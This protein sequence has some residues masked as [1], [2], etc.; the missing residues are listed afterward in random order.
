MEVSKKLKHRP[1]KEEDAAIYRNTCNLS[2]RL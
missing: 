2:K 1:E